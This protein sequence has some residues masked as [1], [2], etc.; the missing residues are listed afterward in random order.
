MWKCVKFVLQIV[1]NCIEGDADLFVC[2]S[3]PFPTK[4]NHTW[5][6]AGDGMLS[7]SG[8]FFFPLLAWFSPSTLFFFWTPIVYSIFYL[9]DHFI[10]LNINGLLIWFREGDDIVTIAPTDPKAKSGSYYI[11]VFGFKST[12]FNLSVSFKSMKRTLQR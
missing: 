9:I 11:G 3:N 5:G 2:N 8:N 7:I 10:S 6:S 4:E 12:K 1:L